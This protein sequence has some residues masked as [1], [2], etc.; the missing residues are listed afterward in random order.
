MTLIKKT[1]FKYDVEYISSACRFFL[2]HLQSCVDHLY[3]VAM[4]DITC[5][6]MV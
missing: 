4:M 5:S 2:E 6:V 3:L 1:M